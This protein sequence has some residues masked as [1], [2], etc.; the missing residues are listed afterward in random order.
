MAYS[1]VAL[2]VAIAVAFF[3]ALGSG[4][5]DAQSLPGLRSFRSGLGTG[6]HQNEAAFAAEREGGAARTRDSLH[7]AR[8]SITGVF[9]RK[10][11]LL[12]ELLDY[13]SWT[14]CPDSEFLS[15]DIMHTSRIESTLLLTNGTYKSQIAELRRDVIHGRHCLRSTLNAYSQSE[16]KYANLMEKYE[17]LRSE[18]EK[19]EKQLRENQSRRVERV[20]LWTVIICGV[21]YFL[22]RTKLGAVLTFLSKATGHSQPQHRPLTSEQASRHLDLLWGENNDKYPGSGALFV[23]SQSDPSQFYLLVPVNLSAG[24]PFALFG[25]GGDYESDLEK[26]KAYVAGRSRGRL[27]IILYK[28]GGSLFEAQELKRVEWVHGSIFSVVG[29]TT[30]V[31]LLLLVAHERLSGYCP[32]VWDSAGDSE[33][34]TDLLTREAWGMTFLRDH[35]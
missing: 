25:T 24:R 33:W 2:M 12:D 29:R 34:V 5:A 18:K 27:S 16:K 7:S 4:Q 8:Y 20:L 28:H 6:Y 9:Q 15:A 23:E 10:A 26:A 11:I 22:A 35:Q 14:I 1:N 19:V 32:A 21:A 3:P 17:S 13:S 30:G 31:K